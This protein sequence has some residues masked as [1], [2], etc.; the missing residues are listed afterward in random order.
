VEASVLLRKRQ[1]VENTREFFS[2]KRVFVRGK[3]NRKD[4]LTEM[5]RIGAIRCGRVRTRHN[6]SGF[7]VGEGSVLD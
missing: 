7:I 3:L 1:L 2:L 5:L 6:Y 4:R